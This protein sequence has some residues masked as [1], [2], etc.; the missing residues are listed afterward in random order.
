MQP[1]SRPIAAV[2]ALLVLAGCALPE[3][4]TEVPDVADSAGTSRHEGYY[5]PPLTSRETYKARAQTLPDSNRSRRL[6]FVSTL[7]AAQSE[8]PY[9]P[10]YFMFA[11]GDEAEKLIIIATHDGPLDTIYRARALLASFT[12]AARETP[13]F[14]ENGVDE[15]FTFYDLLKLLGFRQLTIS[16][17]KSFA[18]R[19][20]ID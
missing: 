13:V 16:D 1:R 19:V 14:Q 4:A 12:Q 3:A 17:G 18:H 15:F 9:L 20:V 5:Y 8:L 7:T 11:K 10:P 2:L 6:V